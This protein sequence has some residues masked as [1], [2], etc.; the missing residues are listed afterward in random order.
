MKKLLWEF[1]IL[2][3]RL[4]CWR[5]AG[6]LRERQDIRKLFLNYLNSGEAIHREPA[7]G[8]GPPPKLKIPKQKE[9]E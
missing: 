5:W 2:I 8:I 7:M 3:Y 1:D 9:L 6:K 4:F